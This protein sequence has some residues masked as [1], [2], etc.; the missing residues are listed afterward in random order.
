MTVSSEGVKLSG[1][2]NTFQY[3]S[4]VTDN[5]ISGCGLNLGTQGGYPHHDETH[6]IKYAGSLDQ[7]IWNTSGMVLELSAATVQL[8]GDTYQLINELSAGTVQNIKEIYSAITELS[9]NVVETINS[10]LTIFSGIV[11]EYVTE[12]LSGINFDE[13]YEYIDSADTIIHERI[14]DIELIVA[15]ALNDLNRRVKEN[16]QAIEES[17]GDI[18]NLS[19]A[20][21]NISGDV[22]NLSAVTVN[23]TTNI[24]NLSGAVMSISALTD[25]VLTLTLNE[26][27]QGKYSPSADTTI[28]LVVTGEVVPLTGYKISSGSTEEEL[29]ITSADTVNEAFGKLQKQIY[30]DE[31]VIAA[32][33]NDLDERI[34]EINNKI[35]AITVVG[36]AETALSATT[37]LSAITSLSAVTA[38]SAVTSLSAITAVSA[39]TADSA[40]TALSAITSLSA[41][42]SLSAITSLSAQTSLSALTALSAKTAEKLDHDVNISLSGECYGSAVTNFSGNVLNIPTFKKFTTANSLSNLDF[43]EFLTVITTGA[44]GTLSVAANGNLPKLPTGGVKEAHVIIS[45]TA[46]TGI[47]ITVNSSDSRLKVTGDN[48]ILID[49]N[50]FGE[51]NALITYNGSTYTIYIITT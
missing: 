21:V 25:G 45:N 33:F 47:T 51:L 2:E 26:T 11:E 41:Q 14:D 40:T 9:G 29:V 34:I 37:S 22:T 13:I 50:N 30:D 49:P 39:K 31:L 17:S 12:A 36:S 5:I 18:L 4:A 23:N 24:N 3:L 6:Y 48:E 8:S 10:S 42:T 44:N 28:N 32:A 43:A 20:T 27:E 46:S 15:S 35:S 7:A 38:L 1:I 16:K 19:A